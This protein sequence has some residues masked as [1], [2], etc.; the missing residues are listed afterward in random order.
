MT[1]RPGDPAVRMA[2]NRLPTPS[3]LGAQ[4]G[5]SELDEKPGNATNKPEAVKSGDAK[6]RPKQSSPNLRQDRRPHVMTNSVR[7]RVRLCWSAHWPDEATGIRSPQAASRPMG[8]PGK[9]RRV[10]GN[11]PQH[12]SEIGPLFGAPVQSVRRLGLRSPSL[13]QQCVA[14]RSPIRAV[15]QAGFGT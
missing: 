15:D 14:L 3:G 9:R 4:C 2:W 12:C 6:S 13:V 10:A 7:H 1:A 5:T 11:G 8:R